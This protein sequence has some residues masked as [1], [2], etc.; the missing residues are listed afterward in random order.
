MKK[1]DII[2]SSLVFVIRSDVILEGIKF[3]APSNSATDKSVSL[4]K[5]LRYYLCAFLAAVY[6]L[7]ICKFLTLF[8]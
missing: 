4:I 5:L 7:L 8:R 6:V 1:D 2:P 3:R